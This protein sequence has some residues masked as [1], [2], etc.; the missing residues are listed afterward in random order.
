MKKRREEMRQL[1]CKDAASAGSFGG[2]SAGSPFFLGRPPFDDDLDD[3]LEDDLDDLEDRAR[4]SSD[5]PSDVYVGDDDDDD[6]VVGRFE[7]S[8]EDS[9]NRSPEA[10]EAGRGR[11]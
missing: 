10:A 2:P 3:D 9:E 8:R 6:D 7:S 4:R 5:S 1:W 11:V